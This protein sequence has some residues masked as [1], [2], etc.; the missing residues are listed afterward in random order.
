MGCA[1]RGHAPLSPVD[2]SARLLGHIASAWQHANP[3]APLA[4]QEVVVTVPASFDEVA[5]T[6]TVDAARQA[7]LAKFTLVEEP[8]AAFYDF[9]ARHRHDRGEVLN[10]VRLVLVVDVGGGTT[11]YLIQV[12]TDKAEDLA[13]RRLAV[14]DHLML[15]GDNMDAALARLAEQ[16]MMADGRRLAAAQWTHLLQT[17]GA[18][19]EALLGSDAPEKYGITVAAEEAVS[20]GGRCPRRSPGRKPGSSSSMVFSHPARQTKRRSV[21]SA[22]P[23]R[24]SGCPTHRIRRSRAISLDFSAS[25]P[26]RR[27]PRLAR[28]QAFGAHRVAAPGCDSAQRRGFQRSDHRRAPGRRRLGLVAGGAPRMP[29]LPHDSLDR[30]VAGGT[31]YYGLARHG[32]AQRIGGGASHA[33]YVGV[34]PAADGTAPR[35]VCLI[36]RGHEEGVQVTLDDRPFSLTL[37]QPG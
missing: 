22:L 16:R 18:A 27:M 30:A 6:L 25:T 14:G 26:R 29:L 7:G 31:A 21:S 9:T 17:T 8:Q 15:G 35:A 3:D 12:G 1:R 5:R 34:A 32:L 4:E 23:F 24:N 36:P 37:G 10:G 13:L 33:L 2:A 19:K 20:W 28:A 11:D